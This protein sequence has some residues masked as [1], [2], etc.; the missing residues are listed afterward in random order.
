MWRNAETGGAEIA[1]R[2]SNYGEYSLPA[3]LEALVDAPLYMVVAVWGWQLGRAFCRDEVAQA[4]RISPHRAADVMSYIRRAR[5]D[6]VKSRQ[7]HTR[8]RGG[9]R[10][11]HLLILSEPVVG[12]CAARAAVKNVTTAPRQGASGAQAETDLQA[13]RHWFL[14]RPNRV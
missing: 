2:Q 1:P 7:H 8:L 10:L 3:G 12:V 6:V 4:F 14:S 13:L 5:P 9:V 11:R